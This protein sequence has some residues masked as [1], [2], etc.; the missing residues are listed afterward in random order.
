[1]PKTPCKAR[2]IDGEPCQGHGLPDYDGYCFAHAAPE[3]LQEWRSRGGKASSTAARAD[4]RIPVRLRG[5]IEKVSKGMDD[6]LDGKLEPAAFSALCRGATVLRDLYRLA[7]QE[8]DLIRGEEIA[9]AAAQVVGGI[10]DPAI[11]DAAAAITDWQK[12]YTLKYLIAQDLVTLEPRPGR[13]TDEPPV[14]ILTAAGRQRFGY[15]RLTEH[16]R[17]EVDT[18]KELA[19]DPSFEGEQL[20]AALHHLYLIRTNLEEFLTDYAP[21]AQ[22][23]LDPFTG[24]PLSQLPVAV[25]PAAVPVAGPE[26]AEQAVKEMQKLLCRANVVTR[27]VEKIYEEQTGRPFDYKE[28]FEEQNRVL[29]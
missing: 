4:K 13:K 19:A 26:E 6:L 1:M 27:D 21:G 28:E 14:H 8:M 17:E 20:P 29:F 16:T 23:V 7:D 22:P 25:K 11:L 24:N 12:D 10:G 2:R 3:K 15:Q 5:A 9:A 18:W